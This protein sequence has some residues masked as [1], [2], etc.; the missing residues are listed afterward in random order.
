MYEISFDED[1][2]EH[3][4]DFIQTINQTRC[5]F[6]KQYWVYDC[7]LDSINEQIEEIRQAEIEDELDLP[8]PQL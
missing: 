6:E 7:L 5:L 3:F 4:K 8:G 1:M 2:F